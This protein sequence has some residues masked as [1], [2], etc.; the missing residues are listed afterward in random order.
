MPKNYCSI[1]S[2]EASEPLFATASHTQVYLLLE[3]HGAWGEK[4]VEESELP[5]AV[6]SRL[7]NFAKSLSAAKL[8][9]IKRT[10]QENQALR[11]FIAITGET[12]I[13]YEFSLQS[14]EDLLEFDFPA[15]LSGGAQYQPYRRAE[16]LYLICTNGRRDACCAK[17]GLPVFQAF[18]QA[19]QSSPQT[20]AWQVTHVGGHRFAANLL[21]L[22]QGLLYGRVAPGEAVDIIRVH[23]QGQVDLTHLRG[24]TCYSEPVQAAE[25]Y[26]RQSTNELGC[27]AFH[28]LDEEPLE[29]QHWRVRF[30]QPAT[31]T[32]YTLVV[33]LEKSSEGVYESCLLDKTTALKTYRLVSL[34][35]AT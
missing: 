35:S 28:L 15:I 18:H 34:E 17:F 21:I 10:A 23:Q 3:Y 16:P 1:L 2:Q 12:P 4:A 27:S 8:L 33:A 11:F 19:T 6:K 22:P 32:V 5:G 13:L 26:L 24:R 25:F 30:T 9:L 29:A 31:Q 20:L 14:Y 7:S